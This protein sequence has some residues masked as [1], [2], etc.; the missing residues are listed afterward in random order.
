MIKLLQDCFVSVDNGSTCGDG[1]CW[2]TCWE[3][4]QFFAGEELD[5]EDW[6]VDIRN[7]EEGV[8]FEFV[9]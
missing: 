1:C 4:E 5:D 9:K 2:N 6:K 8:D 7:L 3:S